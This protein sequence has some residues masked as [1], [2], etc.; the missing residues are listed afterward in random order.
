MQVVS[1]NNKKIARNT[2]FLYLRMFLVLVVSLFTTRV[3]LHALGVQDY[4]INNVVCGFVS[5][6]SFLNT[7]MANGV[8][9]FYNF[10]LGRKTEY[11]IGEVYTASF[12]IQIIIA[13]LL[14]VILELVG[15][16]YIYNMMN[17]PSDRLS[18]AYWIFQFSVV[19]L[20]LI[21]FQIPYSAAI[22]AYEKMDYYAYLSI[23][24]VVAKLIIAY[25]V[26][27]ASIDRLILYGSLNLLL[28]IISF[29]LYFIYAKIQFPDL[30]F[31][32][33]VR[34]RLF[35]PMLAFSGW[36]VFGSFAYLI[37]GQGL[38][39]LLN[40]FFGAIVNAARG[41]SNMVMSAIQGFQA[42]IVIA[43]RPQLVQSYAEGNHARV[44]RLFYSLSKISFVLLSILSI[45]VIVEVN[46]ILKIWLGDNIPDYTVPFTILALL[47]MIVSSLNTPVSQVVHATGKMK[48]YQ[49]GTSVVICSILPIA[50]LFLKLGCDPT[51]VYWISLIVTVLNQVI[52]NILLKK[53]FDYSIIDYTVKVILPCTSFLV[54]VPIVPLAITMCMP[55]SFYRLIITGLSSV[56]ISF[57]VSY[58]VVLDKAE[59][60]MLIG[61]IRKRFTHE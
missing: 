9:R 19:S 29:L 22:M 7:S 35:K 1:T 46:Y 3:V 39:L 51:L 27:Y 17:I 36:N 56:V 25:S 57:A 59:K 42:N 11:S 8:Q 53:V 44:L 54:L 43:F 58:L 10:S 23:F 45:P 52:C 28:S 38:N 55:S 33:K 60:E 41:V 18:A 50:W 26:K 30:R 16:W 4:G 14:F 12:I 5:M 49:I 24:D 47:N 31:D 2:L 15:T 37:K 20:V 6:F 40:F 21:L 32:F 13:V 61:F 48:S 34:K